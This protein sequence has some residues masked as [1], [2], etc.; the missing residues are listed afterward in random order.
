M[1]V[2]SEE[3]ALSALKEVQSVCKACCKRPKRTEN[4]FIC[5]VCS[6]WLCNNCSEISEDLYNM[7]TKTSAKISFICKLCNEQLPKVRDLIK[8][9]QKQ[10]QM[11]EDIAVM[12]TQINQNKNYIIKQKETSDNHEIRLLKVEKLLEDNHLNDNEFPSLPKMNAETNL[13]KQQLTYQQATTNKLDAELQKHQQQSI[14]EKQQALRAANL[15]IYGFPETEESESEQM[16]QDFNSIQD[17][18]SDRV[19]IIYSDFKDIRRLGTKKDKSR[20]IRVTCT[21]LEKRKEILVNNIGLR[22]QSDDFE[23]CKCKQ[24]PG[25]HLHINITNDKTRNQRETEAKLREELQSRR[26]AGEQNIKIRQGKI[27]KKDSTPAHP[28]WADLFENGY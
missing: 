8:L 26:K 10:E 16:K 9:S 24:N 12:K 15:I 6:D 21:S 28:R 20:P 3:R 13:L 18:L 22:I 11:E 23:E 25:R 5:D 27:V 4:I 17:I 1:P 19:D 2:I 14:E 7:A